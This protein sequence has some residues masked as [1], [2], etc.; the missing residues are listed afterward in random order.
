MISLRWSLVWSW[1]SSVLFVSQKLD[2]SCAIGLAI[3]KKKGVTCCPISALLTSGWNGFYSDEK[4]M[5]CLKK[6]RAEVEFVVTCVPHLW[7][8]DLSLMLADC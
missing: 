6:M 7:S 8:M 1:Q 3:C 4:A 2:F 5:T